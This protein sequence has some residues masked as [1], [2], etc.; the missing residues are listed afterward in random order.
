MLDIVGKVLYSSKGFF[1]QHR[2]ERT[3]MFGSA[4]SLGALTF[5]SSLAAQTTSFGV[6]M[7]IQENGDPLELLL[8]GRYGERNKNVLSN[9]IFSISGNLN[10]AQFQKRK[11]FIKIVYYKTTGSY[12]E[13]MLK[14]AYAVKDWLINPE[15]SNA[16]GDLSPMKFNVSN[17]GRAKSF[18]LNPSDIR[19]EQVDFSDP[20]AQ[21]RIQIFPEPAE[22]VYVPNTQGPSST[23]ISVTKAISVI[24]L[25]PDNFKLYL[26]NTILDIFVDYDLQPT[27]TRTTSGNSQSAQGAND[28]INAS[29]AAAAQGA[30]NS[31]VAQQD[32]ANAATA[33]QTS[34]SR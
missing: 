23:A 21:T 34:G 10:K 25:S 14:L 5:V 22:V 27:V 9:I 11:K 4:Q 12:T 3:D 26:A 8:N 18:G 33:Q 19:I 13:D 6:D 17:S 15:S 7:R 1:D 29:R 32:A 20:E 24:K 28:S 2:T 16:A 31:A 30:A